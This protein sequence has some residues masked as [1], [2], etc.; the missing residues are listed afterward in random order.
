MQENNED[1]QKDDQSQKK[2]SIQIIQNAQVKDGKEPPEN[3]P[4]NEQ[5]SQREHADRKTPENEESNS[6]L[7]Q[8]EEE[9]KEKQQYQILKQSLRAL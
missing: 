1:N 8:N 5:T 3:Q 9:I 6:S 2:F 7:S 4:L